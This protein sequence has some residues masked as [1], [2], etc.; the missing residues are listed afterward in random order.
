MITFEKIVDLDETSLNQLFSNSNEILFSYR[1]MEISESL[2]KICVIFGNGVLVIERSNISNSRLRAFL[3]IC[4]RKGLKFEHIYSADMSTIRILYESVEDA[5]GKDISDEQP[6][7]KMASALLTEGA[8]RKASDI[9]I[10]INQ[11]EAEIIFRINGDMLR[12]RQIESS[13]A[14]SLLSTFYNAADNADATYKLYEYQAARIT[15][16]GRL[17][18]P[19]ELQS[20]RLQFNPLSAGGRYMIGRLLYAERFSTKKVEL[21]DMGF[22]PVQIKLLRSLMRKPEGINI[23]AGPTGSGKSTTLKLI[24]ES[25]YKEKNKKVNIMSIE[26]PPEY[27]IEGTSQLPVTN[28]ESE[29]ERE[30]AY[31]K[32]IV[33][34][35]RSDPDIIMPGEARDASV[36]NLVFTAA[37]TG[38]QVWTS[39]H[40]NSAIGVFDRL[41]DQRVEAYKLTDPNLMTGVISQRLVKRLC[42]HCKVPMIDDGLVRYGFSS[43]TILSCF[44]FIARETFEH[45]ASGCSHCIG[46]YNGRTALIEIIVPDFTFLDLISRGQRQEANEHWLNNLN[47][48]SIYEHAWLKIADGVISP[49]DALLRIGDF[50]LITEDRKKKLMELLL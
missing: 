50:T 36:I 1:D 32:A 44:N 25:I 41:K 10:K 15:N 42:P 2:R 29:E 3:M 18:L 19:N 5:P 23:V 4:E 21:S 14:H 35:L 49:Y 11:H 30:N 22:H 46:G 39:I 8:Q 34:A 38:H 20:V 33:S 28:A 26:D 40:A 47:G 45:N 16:S 6:M 13:L 31:S 7:E 37:M 12:I 24:L 48:I 17:N 27:Q 43:S 9:H